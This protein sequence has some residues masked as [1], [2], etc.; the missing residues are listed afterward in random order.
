MNTYDDNSIFMTHDNTNFD[1]KIT[2]TNIFE[3][4]PNE[5]KLEP[6]DNWRELNYI[7]WRWRFLK[8]NINKNTKNVVEISYIKPDSKER[9]FFNKKGEWVTRNVPQEYDEFVEKQFY[10]YVESN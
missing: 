4:I 6:L 7:E 5:S 8:F 10:Y 9:I 1:G 2:F 3:S